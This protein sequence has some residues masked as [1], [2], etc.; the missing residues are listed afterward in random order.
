MPEL[1]DIV[2]YVEALAARIRGK[3]LLSARIAHPFLLR[4]YDPPIAALHGLRVADLSRI[5]KRIAIGF[6]QD[7]WLLIHLMIAGRLHWFDAAKPKGR[8]VLAQLAFET[9]TLTLTEAGTKR[10]ASLAVYGSS[11]RVAEQDRGGLEV[12]DAP[13][14]DFRRR[15]TAT[16]HTLKRALTD[17]RLFSGIGNAYSMKSCIVRACRRSL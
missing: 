7:H 11:A 16:N 10:R 1:P 17:P 6:E 12:L 5:G 2:A 3:R 9:G 4:T 8:N 14:E 15:L 13:V